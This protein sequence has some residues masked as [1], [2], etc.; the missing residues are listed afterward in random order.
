MSDDQPIYVPIEDAIDLH[1]FAPCDIV[2]VVDEYLRAAHDAGFRLV[3]LIHGRGRGVQ[4][5]VIQRLLSTHPLV[6][7]YWDAPETHLGATM[8]RLKDGGS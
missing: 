4:R 2:S 5:A 3:R 1:P 6:G 8:V 7:A